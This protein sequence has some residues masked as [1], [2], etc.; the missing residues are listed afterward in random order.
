MIPLDRSATFALDLARQPDGFLAPYS[1]VIDELRYAGLVTT[2][3]VGNG[4]AIVK[5]VAQ[6]TPGLARRANNGRWYR[7]VAE[8]RV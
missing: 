1:E 4:F 7:P 5:A 2:K 8:A 3:D 6:P